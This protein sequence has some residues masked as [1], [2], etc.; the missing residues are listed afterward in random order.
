IQFTESCSM[1]Q[2]AKEPLINY[3]DM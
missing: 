2:S 1:D 3:L